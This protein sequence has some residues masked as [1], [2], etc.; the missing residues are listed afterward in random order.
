VNR[1]RIWKWLRCG[2]VVFTSGCIPELHDD[3]SLALEGQII[4]VQFE[5]AEARPEGPAQVKAL[6]AADTSVPASFSLCVARKPLSELG[7]V[8][9]D[10]L[11]S[12]VDNDAL[13]PLGVGTNIDFTVP[14]EAC[15]LF[16]PQRPAAEPGQ[17]PGRPVDP[18]ATGGFYQPVV[19]QSDNPVLGSLR[20]DCGLPGG[21]QAQVAQYNQ[22]H[23]PNENPSI[24]SLELRIEQGEW[25]TFDPDSDVVA[26]APR[27]KRVRVRS[28]WDERER[29]L[30]LSPEGR[31]LT[32]KRESLIATFYSTIGGF[33]EHRVALDEQGRVFS[34]LQLGDDRGEVRVWIVVRDGRGGTG[35][36]SFKL[37]V[38]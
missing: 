10:C 26:R 27:N 18:D 33:D 29:Y 2:T 8:H 25:Q 30:F 4:A 16:G 3:P 7:P 22:E 19:A 17:P 6:V 21:S 9:P 34:D 32:H 28:R 15:R 13:V 31:E 36:S 24:R 14:K 11:A 20:L 12:P 1:Q 23:E 5:P 35:F 37:D 38:R